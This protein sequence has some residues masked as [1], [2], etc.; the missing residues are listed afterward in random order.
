MNEPYPFW[1]EMMTSSILTENTIS[2]KLHCLT[3]WAEI[4]KI[5]HAEFRATENMLKMSRDWVNIRVMNIVRKLPHM[6][7]SV[8]SVS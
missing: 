1:C 5:T 7:F 4:N 2:M 8:Q 3:I 6:A